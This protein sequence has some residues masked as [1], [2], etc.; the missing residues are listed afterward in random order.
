MEFFTHPWYMAAGGAAV[1]LPILIHLINRMRFKRIRWAAMEF[2][3]KSQKR[4]RRRLIIEQLILLLLRILLMLLAGFLVARFLPVGAGARGG[5][6][7]IVVD[8]T[9][10]MRDRSKDADAYNAG[11]LQIKKI[12][13]QA[14]KAASRQEIQV[15]L[16]SEVNKPSPF[17]EDVISDQTSRK[18]ADKF[19]A[20]GNRP[21]MLH[22]A[23]LPGLQKGRELLNNLQGDAPQ[24]SRNLYFISDFRDADWAASSD[25]EKIAAEVKAAV[26]DGIHVNL[27]DASLPVRE[28]E[29]NSKIALFSDN[30]AITDLTAD[31]RVPSRS[32]TSR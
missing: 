14:N 9:L 18:I 1:S 15:F 24:G 25:S 8:D 7:V 16:L 3:L 2:L 4:N 27:I 10:S 13:E 22:A 19:A 29:A 6:H 30:V 32:P 21:T 12:V 31:T 28:K 11:L 26:E 20:L 5:T 23:P 17:Y